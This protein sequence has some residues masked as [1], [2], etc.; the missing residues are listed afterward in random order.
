MKDKLCKSHDFF[1]IAKSAKAKPTSQR[2]TPNSIHTSYLHNFT[3]ALLGEDPLLS[4]ALILSQKGNKGRLEQDVF[5][6]KS[7]KLSQL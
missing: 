2:K 7:A 5:R 1:K 6:S 4:S 3:I